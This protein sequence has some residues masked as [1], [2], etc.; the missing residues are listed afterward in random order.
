MTKNVLLLTSPVQVVEPMRDMAKYRI[1]RTPMSIGLSLTG[2]SSRM[3]LR[4]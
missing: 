4:G 2:P 3:G 1:A